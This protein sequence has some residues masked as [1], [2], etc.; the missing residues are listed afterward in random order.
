MSNLD[1]ALSHMW[2][3]IKKGMDFAI[4]HENTVEALKLNRADSMKLIEKYDKCN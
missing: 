4:A 2:E 1:K 3:Q